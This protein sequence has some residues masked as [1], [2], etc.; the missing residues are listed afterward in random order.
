MMNSY[1]SIQGCLSEENLQRQTNEE[2]LCYEF[3]RGFE[4]LEFL[5]M[6][7]YVYK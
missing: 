4:R 2:S 1:E 6:T 5:T 7:K 3:L